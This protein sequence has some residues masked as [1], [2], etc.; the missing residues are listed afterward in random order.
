M[1]FSFRPTTAGDLPALSRFL[2][3]AFEA[4]PN[5]PFLNPAVMAWKYWERRDDWTEPRSYVLERDG[6]IVAHAGIW[7]LTFGEGDKT[8]RGIQMI[9]WGSAREAPGAGLALCQR[10]ATIFDFIYSI[11][12]SEATRRILPAFG[13]KE[14]T[15]QWRGACPLHPIR[16]ILTHQN[17]NWKLAPRLV[18]NWWWSVRGRTPRENWK[19]IEISPEQ[20]QPASCVPS[21]A[22]ALF[23]PRPP[24]FFAYLL[25]CPA[26]RFRLYGIFDSGESRGYFVTGVVRAQARIAG[27][28]LCQPTQNAWAAAYFLARRTAQTWNEPNEVVVAGSGDTA[29]EGAARAGFRMIGGTAVYVLDPKKNLLLSPDFQFQLSDDD[30]GFLESTAAY[31]T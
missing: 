10:L 26:A 11:G 3:R 5:A 25:R 12:G 9:D 4:G 17:R 6:T 22:E 27:I 8:L 23:S 20:I 31:W 30:A 19:A 29:R 1:K 13:F 7:P 18:R 21:P 24:A 28:W 16:Q 15:R 14:Y 2:V